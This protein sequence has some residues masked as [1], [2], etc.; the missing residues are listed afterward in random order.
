MEAKRQEGRKEGQKKTAESKPEL[1]SEL[2]NIKIK[3]NSLEKMALDLLTL[4]RWTGGI[5]ALGPGT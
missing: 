1:A 3:R 5:S 4:M 2:S